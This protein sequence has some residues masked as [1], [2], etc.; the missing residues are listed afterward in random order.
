MKSTLE[1]IYFSIT[2]FHSFNKMN[3]RNS[4]YL[5][6][7]SLPIENALINLLPVLIQDSQLSV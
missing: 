6:T 4:R 2:H 7:T 5:K 3:V 1:E